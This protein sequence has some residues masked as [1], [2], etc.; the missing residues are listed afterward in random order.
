MPSRPPRWTPTCLLQAENDN[1]DGPSNSLSYYNALKD[2][3]VP[4][5]DNIITQL[6]TT[7]LD[8]S[9]RFYTT[10]LGFTL[11]FRYEDFYAGVQAGGHFVHLKLVDE[12]DPSIAYVEA[13]EHFHLYVETADVTAAADHL[14]EQGVPLV[15]DVHETTWGTRECVI[16][17]D[18]GHTIYIGQRL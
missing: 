9:I 2:A 4:Q 11:E 6:R 15:R 3:G 1:V 12:V 17:D 14:R 10:K 7:S 18:Q 16:K 5:I 13:G 8:E